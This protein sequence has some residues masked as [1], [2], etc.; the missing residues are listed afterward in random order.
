MLFLLN[1]ILFAN[2]QSNP[3]MRVEWAA[4]Y[5]DGTVVVQVSIPPDTDVTSAQIETTSG[6]EQLTIQAMNNQTVYWLVLDTSQEMVNV[7]PAVQRGLVN[8]VRFFN[9][10][11]FGIIMYDEIVT[12]QAISRNAVTI[13][14]LLDNYDPQFF[15]QSAIGCVYDA[16]T[17]LADTNNNGASS[18]TA[19]RIL[20]VSGDITTQSDC[21]HE[22]FEDF[23]VPIDV[24]TIGNG[25]TDALVAIANE[26]NGVYLNSRWQQLQEQ[27]ANIEN[28]WSRPIY[29][30][31]SSVGVDIDLDGEVLVRLSNDDETTLAIELR[32]INGFL[33]DGRV[34]VSPT[35]TVTPTATNTDIPTITP[36]A[37]NTDTPIPP[38]LTPTPT[39]TDTAIPP[40]HTSTSTPTHIVPTETVTPTE[41]DTAIPL[42][43]ADTAQTE[44]SETP[45][46]QA[47]IVAT[48]LP[49]TEISASPSPVEPT[50]TAIVP[51]QIPVTPQTDVAVTNL[52][53]TNNLII[54]IGGIAVV[55][56]IIAVIYNLVQNTNQQIATITNPP[57]DAGDTPIVTPPAILNDN[58]YEVRDDEVVP[59]PKR[60][61]S[62][63]QADAS[64]LGYTDI[65][66]FDED[67]DGTQV[68]A[69]EK[70]QE[71][72]RIPSVAMLVENED[73]TPY[74]ITRPSTLLG[75]G[76]AC[77]IM[78]RGDV[79]I[80]QEH[81][82]FDID[83]DNKVMIT[84][85][86]D[87]AVYV[88]G[89]RVAD[90][91]QLQS[92]DEIQ[93]SPNIKVTF[94][95]VED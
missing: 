66:D 77:Q 79:A 85:L 16:L 84:V 95:Y 24:L 88:N 68:W 3:E 81:L 49:V 83:D 59:V 50:P 48:E 47:N 14:E 22:E 52:T 36:T 33:P 55:L 41:T 44:P 5:A 90:T 53:T 27:L 40:T 69:I 26:T 64:A 60:K 43:V 56:I 34:Y 80:A 61:V 67:D 46:S 76:P 87:H 78:L 54:I 75:S 12:E 89:K 21:I 9:T 8:L 2:A 1:W 4:Q 30:L 25:D 38:T 13:E 31:S 17:T 92:G 32:A 51:S 73:D 45:I 7:A 42:T 29:R 70:L 20:L 82:L 39:N 6:T 71:A 28:H 74:D 19:W 37:T 93:L 10:K 23:G 15:N 35:P 18:R 58:F 91:L 72:I 57:T 65:D 11:P 86:T 62:A 94:N 63:T